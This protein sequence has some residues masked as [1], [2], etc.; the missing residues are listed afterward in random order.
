[1]TKESGGAVEMSNHQATEQMLGYLYQVRYAL[2]LLLDNSDPNCQISIEKFDDVAF[3]KDG[4]PIQLIQ[5]KHHIKK[6]GNLTDNST[7]LWRTLKVWIDAITQK[8][9]ILRET[10]F[11]IITTAVAPENEASSY[12]KRDDNRDTATAYEKLKKVCTQ[13][14]NKDHQKYYQAFIKL[15][16]ATMKQL[17][18]RIYILDGASNIVGVEQTIRRNIRYSSIPKYE[19]FIFERLEGWWFQKAVNALCSDQP[20]FVTQNQVRAFIVT[21][22]QE[23]SDENLPIEDIFNLDDLKESDLSENEKIFY[24]QLKLICLSRV[25]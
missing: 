14:K 19:K 22:S 17:F 15:D 18:E 20:I 21:I 8:P 5:L 2:A 10:E 13:S 6:Q 25:Y 4:E 12:L 24:E 1:M 9:D 11:L 7:D 16:E 23:Y 3:G